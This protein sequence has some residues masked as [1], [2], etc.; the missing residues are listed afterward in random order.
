MATARAPMIGAIRAPGPLP[1]I[2]RG[3]RSRRRRLSDSGGKIP[4]QVL[5]A[6][7]GPVRAP[8]QASLG[9]TVLPRTATSAIAAAA[10]PF[11]RL[12]GA[13][14]PSQCRSPRPTSS[15]S[16]PASANS[17]AIRR[18]FGRVRSRLCACREI[19]RSRYAARWC[20]RPVG[21]QIAEG[22]GPEF[23]MAQPGRDHDAAGAQCIAVIERQAKA[24]GRRLDRAHGS[25]VDIRDRVALKPFA[26][27]DKILERQ[28]PVGGDAW[29][30]ARRRARARRRGLKY[31]S[32]ATAS[33]ASC[34]SAYG[35]AK[36]PSARQA[37]ASR[38][39]QL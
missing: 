11:V 27:T 37:R 33:A 30:A 34:L 18:R 24:V 31:G 6:E 19:S 22:F 21:P 15:T 8:R 35:A 25:P 17:A 29:A 32:R 7:N 3:E 36:T 13:A 10:S 16:A 12:P 1:Q 5:P 23:L 38:R 28:Q 9:G 2:A 4:R 20:G 14:A 39:R 26:V